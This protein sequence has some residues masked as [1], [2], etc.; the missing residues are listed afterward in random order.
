M[1]LIEPLI[2]WQEKRRGLCSLCF[3]RVVIEKRKTWEWKKIPTTVH[4]VNC[5]QVDCPGH[6]HVSFIVTLSICSSWHILCY[7]P[8]PSSSSQ[9]S[10]IWI[11]HNKW[12]TLN[13]KQNTAKLFSIYSIWPHVDGN[14]W[15]KYSVSLKMALPYFQK[16][17]C[18]IT[19]ISPLCPLLVMLCYCML[20][21]IS[22]HI[23]AFCIDGILQGI[24]MGFLCLTKPTT[25]A[26]LLYK[27]TL[28][29]TLKVIK[30]FLQWHEESQ[31]L[32]V[33]C[34]I[35]Y[36][37]ELPW[38]PVNIWHTSLIR[39]DLEDISDVR[40]LRDVPVL[41]GTCAWILPM[42]YMSLIHLFNVV[43]SLYKTL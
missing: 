5:V 2:L 23:Y 11:T 8:F 43:K 24:C 13:H 40:C 26:G 21:P 4:L 7:W 25:T 42:Y 28:Q 41:A 32:L 6:F 19:W 20:V 27:L 12:V 34:K 31:N 3:W 14:E 18:P 10:N 16:R 33:P 30:A 37:I 22:N 17:T 29:L 39:L 38:L 9:V 36:Q 35:F 15:I 1:F